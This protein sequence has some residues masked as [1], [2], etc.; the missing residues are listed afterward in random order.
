MN[1]AFEVNNFTGLI[2]REIEVIYT[3]DDS[4]KDEFGHDMRNGCFSLDQVF[5][6]GVEITSKLS[7]DF[8][9]HLKNLLI[10]ELYHKWK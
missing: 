4:D 10:E 3:D 9:D 2:S 5:F 6:K 8:T 1:H 7:L